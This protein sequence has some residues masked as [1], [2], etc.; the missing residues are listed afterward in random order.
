MRLKTKHP[1][2]ASTLKGPRTFPR[3]GEVLFLEFFV[4]RAS[5]R[6][7]PKGSTRVAFCCEIRSE[8]PETVH[9]TK[10]LE[11]TRQAQLLWGREGE[12]AQSRRPTVVKNVGK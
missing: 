11:N 12:A 8:L 7:G 5:S 9:R 4:T 3:C 10:L 6:G 1:F 2:H